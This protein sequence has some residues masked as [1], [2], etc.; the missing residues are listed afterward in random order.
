ML[1]LPVSIHVHSKPIVQFYDDLDQSGKV[2]TPYFE[3][4]SSIRLQF[5][6]THGQLQSTV[7]GEKCELLFPN[8]C[9]R[10][11]AQHTNV[12]K[13]GCSVV[14]FMP[15]NTKGTGNGGETSFCGKRGNTQCC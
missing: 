5:S 11:G 2:N 4:I 9:I 1:P 7:R 14:V 8:V 10:N 15:K 3:Q 13:P 12:C 6:R